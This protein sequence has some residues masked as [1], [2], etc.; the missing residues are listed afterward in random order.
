P[1]SGPWIRVVPTAAGLAAY[2][3]ACGFELSGEPAEALHA[4]L[5]YPGCQR[6]PILSFLKEMTD[7]TLDFEIDPGT[8]AALR[9]DAGRLA[10]HCGEMIGLKGRRELSDFMETIAHGRSALRFVRNVKDDVVVV[11][12]GDVAD[13]GNGT[14]VADGGNGAEV[15]D[16][17]RMDPLAAGAFEQSCRAFTAHQAA[18][19]ARE[20]CRDG[21]RKKAESAMEKLRAENPGG[22]KA[23]EEYRGERTRAFGCAFAFCLRAEQLSGL[24]LINAGCSRSP[25]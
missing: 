1:D 9:D 3:G 18:L 11:H 23:M 2:L 8:R 20:A 21:F 5:A 10:G 6:P 16:G 13:G 4:L 15:A 12:D 22:M 24:G 14:E 7:D 25:T 17:R 19:T